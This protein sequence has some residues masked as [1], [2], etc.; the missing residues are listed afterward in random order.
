MR[1]VVLV[2]AAVAVGVPAAAVE[3]FG[4]PLE[5]RPADDLEA[6]L[7]APQDGQR[8]HL[9]GRIEAVCRN[10]GCWLELKQGPGSIHVT[11][12]DYSFLVP[13]NTVGRQVVLEGRVKLD[14]P[15]PE[16][17]EHLVGEGARRAAAGVSVIASGV[18]IR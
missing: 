4:K 3:R 9:E 10:K 5:G 1:L 14:K 8:V 18:E 15:A 2:L 13:K 17:L 7:K 16:Q 6:I 11:F 12:E